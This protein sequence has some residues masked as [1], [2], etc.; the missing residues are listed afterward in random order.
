MT[1]GIE[2]PVEFF[3]AVDPKNMYVNIEPPEGADLDYIDQITKKV[4]LAIN[5]LGGDQQFTSDQYEDAFAMREHKK[6]DGTT[7]MGPR[8]HR[9]YRTYL[10]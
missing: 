2:K 4:E 5:N 8:Q 7:F 3:P 1:V 10:R 9:Q 6:A